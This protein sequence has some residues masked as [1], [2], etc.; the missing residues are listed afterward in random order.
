[1]NSSSQPKIGRSGPAVRDALILL[2]GLFLATSVRVS[3][4][5]A[6]APET[7]L[8]QPV[9]GEVAVSSPVLD[10]LPH[11]L[12]APSPVGFLSMTQAGRSGACTASDHGG[13]QLVVAVPANL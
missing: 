12:P 10:G 9:A 2:A 11:E 5:T 3:A 4:P 6:P 1:V 7:P 8:L 13:A